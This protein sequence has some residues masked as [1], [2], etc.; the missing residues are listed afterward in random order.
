MLMPFWLR[1]ALRAFQQTIDVALSAVER[2]STLIYLD[3][4]EVLLLSRAKDMDHMEHESP[5]LRDAWVT[6]KQKNVPSW[7][8]TAIF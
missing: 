5:L 6:L 7:Q 2:N 3:N 8:K 1:K 4:M